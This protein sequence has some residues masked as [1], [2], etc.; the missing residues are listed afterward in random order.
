MS[1]MLSGAAHMSRQINW[2]SSGCIHLLSSRASDSPRT[3]MI[4]KIKIIT[5]LYTKFK[6]NRRTKDAHCALKLVSS[7]GTWLLCLKGRFGEGHV[8][9]QRPWILPGA[10]CLHSGRGVPPLP[11][12]WHKWKKHTYGWVCMS[13]LGHIHI[14]TA[15]I[16]VRCNWCLTL[17]PGSPLSPLGPGSPTPTSPWQQK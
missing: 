11:I 10:L 14:R 15:S 1:R 17:G 12:T 4:K 8:K 3:L 2:K 9:R 6:L 5:C 16:R 13:F 7:E